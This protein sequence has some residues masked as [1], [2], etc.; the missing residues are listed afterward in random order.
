MSKYFYIVEKC[1]D[2]NMYVG[3][4]P[5]MQGAHSQSETLDGL[6]KNMEDV[7]RLIKKDRK[8]VV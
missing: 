8:T 3:Y 6:R 1:P 2:T 4:V 7:I 5:N